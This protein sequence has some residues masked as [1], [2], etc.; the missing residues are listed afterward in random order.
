MRERITHADDKLDLL[1]H[2]LGDVADV[3]GDRLDRQAVRP[4]RSSARSR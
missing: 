1:R 2:E 4:S 3:A